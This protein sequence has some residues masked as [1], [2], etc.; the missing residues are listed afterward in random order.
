MNTETHE[1]ASQQPE[2]TILKPAN[3]SQ[4]VAE[5]QPDEAQQ[6]QAA[7]SIRQAAQ[8][9]SW[10]R[11]FVLNRMIPNLA[12]FLSE[13]QPLI[14]LLAL[15]IGAASAYAAIAFRMA[16]G[17]FQLPWLG[18]MSE[19][20]VEAAAN[21]QWWIILLAPAS[22]G[23]LV[24]L[25][26]HFLQP[27]RR[28]QAVADVIESSAVGRCRI[29]AREGL[30]SALA[31]ALTLGTGGSAG[32]E[33]PVVH[34]GATLAS[35]LEQRFQLPLSAQRTLLASGVAGAV[36]ASFNAPIAG[37]LFAHEVILRHYALRA[38]VPITIASVTATVIARVHLG[39]FPA[40]IIP[41]YQITSNWEFPAFA[42][43]GVTS[44]A[45]SICFQFA[46]VGADRIAAAI[47]IPLWI[48]PA[49]GGLAVGAIA[50]V[51]PQVLGVGYDTTDAVLKNELMLATMFA[52]L[53]AKTLATAI[54]L[55]SR[56]G[57]GVFSPSLYLGA[58]T[59]GAFGLI[60]ASVFPQ[61][62]SS[63]GLY[64]I[65]GMGA[66]AASVLGAPISTTLIVFELTGGYQMTIALLLTISICNGLTQ[67]VHGVS[68]FHWQLNNRGLF[69]HEGPHQHIVHRLLVRDF[70][71]PLAEDEEPVD[72][73]DEAQPR[74][75]P[76]HSLRHAL[77][78]FD[79]TGLNRLPVIDPAEARQVGWA[80][81]FNALN[82]YNKA[83]IAAH[84]EEHR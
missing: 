71:M 65:L 9:L 35:L 54:T 47:P 40:F 37:V 10:A 48:K 12:E 42:L 18:T 17:I 80:T 19:S 22:G 2:D 33:G 79:E 73:A 1:S 43:L 60:A 30:L 23:L 64:A 28:V 21:T 36:A 16:I 13:R 7:W 59:G 31:S 14:W 29:S 6:A 67:A 58:M 56:L 25:L 66:V 55:A 76:N 78:L 75:R 34:L 45:V 52:L 57:G 27:S 84:V 5:R 15:V 50:I 44:A 70:M 74:L 72:V 46:L 62:A 51:F 61:V 81:H 69:L 82:A 8:A 63:E 41:E 32:R 53:F 26:L 77:R 39:N 24:G 68:Y 3:P 49:L 83:L 11:A 4:Q 38:F 20:V